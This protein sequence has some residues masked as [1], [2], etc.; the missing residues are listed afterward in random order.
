MKIPKD[1]QA[2]GRP[3]KI[4]FAR[5]SPLQVS[6]LSST[7]SFKESEKYFILKFAKRYQTK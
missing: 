1:K 7:K 5:N 2:I 4:S 3:Y 6:T